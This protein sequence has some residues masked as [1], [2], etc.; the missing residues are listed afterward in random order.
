[1]MNNESNKY[2]MSRAKI[3]KEVMRPTEQFPVHFT[4][5]STDGL[6]LKNE[7]RLKGEQVTQ[8]V[9]E[10]AQKLA[11]TTFNESRITIGSNQPNNK[12]K[13]KRKS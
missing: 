8:E 13:N 3:L 7:Y 2:N 12:R 5:Y 10:Q 11:A 1:M 4:Q 6:L 9:Y